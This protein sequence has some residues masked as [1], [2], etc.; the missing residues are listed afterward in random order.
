MWLHVGQRCT[1]V[2]FYVAVFLIYVTVLILP[3][4]EAV[5]MECQGEWTMHG[6][7]RGVGDRD[8]KIKAAESP[9]RWQIATVAS[10]TICGVMRGVMN[11]SSSV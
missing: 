8:S 3:L 7:G 1:G 5:H 9:P 6:W 10:D 2:N 11:S 4:M